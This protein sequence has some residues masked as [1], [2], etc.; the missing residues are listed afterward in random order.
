[1]NHANAELIRHFYTAF[2]Q[3]DAESM[4]A[5]YTEDVHFRDP[6]FGELHGREAAD[7]WRMLCQRA[8]DFSLTFD[9]ITADDQRGTAHWVATYTFTQ[10]GRT[11][12][13][14]IHAEFV[15]RDGRIARH[16]DHFDLWRWT[17][18][19]LGLKGLLL[20]WLPAVQ[21]AV[22]RQARQGLAAWQ[23]AQQG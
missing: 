7:M 6:A 21:G 19:A 10:T 16:Y 13:N 3:L 5:C 2:Q 9:G 23:R 22:H 4:T 20:G 18:Q 15:F 11:V 17:R 1:M 12:V 14:D 8:K